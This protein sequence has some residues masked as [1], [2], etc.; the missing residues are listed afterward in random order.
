MV[1]EAAV[2][3]K[4]GNPSFSGESLVL[5]LRRTVGGMV[6]LCDRVCPILGSATQIPRNVCWIRPVVP[7]QLARLLSNFALMAACHVAP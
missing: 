4:N 1:E 3:N 6:S 7:S 5:Q 2:E